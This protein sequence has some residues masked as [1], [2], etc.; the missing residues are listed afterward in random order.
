MKLLA[1]FLLIGALG[2]ASLAFGQ[3]E[4][5]QWFVS[6]AAQDGMMEVELGTLASA[7]AQTAEVK[8]FAVRMVTD[9]SKANSELEALAKAK[10]LQV[11]TKLDAQHQSTVEM[12]SAKAG[13]EFDAAYMHHM[14]T[15]HAKAVAL[16]ERASRLN[17]TELAEFAKKTLPTLK[18]HKQMAD[19]FDTSTGE[20]ATSSS[21]H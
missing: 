13:A 9:H 5:P 11:P 18:A 14:A 21:S 16:F 6:T 12:L 3:A 15:A 10:S 7:Q 20:P 2:T 8:R 1:L 17:D 19:S 4:T